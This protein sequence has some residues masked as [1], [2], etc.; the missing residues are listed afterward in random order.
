MKIMRK[1]IMSMTEKEKRDPDVKA[2]WEKL[3][4]MG[5]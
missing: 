5:K 1:I 3:V 2:H 4:E